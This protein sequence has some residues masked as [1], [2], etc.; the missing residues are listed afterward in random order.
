MNRFSLLRRSFRWI[1]P[2][3]A[4]LVALLQ[5]APAARLALAADEAAAA[6]PIG[7]VLRNAGAALGALGAI[8]T[9]AGATVL[10]ATA[11]SPV[12]VTVGQAAQPIVFTVTNTIAIGT[13]SIGG[14]IPPGMQ[15]TAVEGGANLSSP[16][17]LD[18]TTPGVMDSYGD[19]SGA[20]TTTTPI[21]SGTPTRAGSYTMTFQAFEYAGNGNLS[22][23]TFNFTVNV[24]SSGPPPS[25][26]PAFTTQPA[27][28]TVAPGTTVV[29]NAAASGTP[30]PTYQWKLNG[31]AISGAT[32]ARLV[33]TG[34]AAGAA[35]AYTCTAT[36][37]AGAVT[38]SA[39]TLAFTATSNPGRLGNISV[40]S[41]FAAGQL[42]TVGFVTGG[43]GTSGT[44]TLLI[45]A[46]GPS[47]AAVAGLS[48]TM[49]HPSLQV[50]PLGQSTVI[51]ANSAW[52]TPASNGTL[53]TAADAATFA[54]P[55]VAGSLDAALV[56]PL[57]PGGYSVQVS[58]TGAGT[59]LTELYDD[60]PLA[61]YTA[62][63]P[64]LV[65]ISCNTSLP[66][67]GSVTAGFT[68][69]GVTAKTV[70][71]RASGPTLASFGLSGTMADP[72]IQVYS[73]STV[74][75]ADA[76]WGGDP[77]IAAAAASV[78]GFAFSS[79][80][81]LDSAVLLTLAPGSY[82]AV[83]SSASGGGGTTVLEVYEVP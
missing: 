54:F 13:W 53:V 2:P 61:A 79:P 40:L 8:H 16:G 52:G 9:L 43:A 22:S 66:T 36:N 37:S 42:L 25:V 47:L 39:G 12:T 76:G 57:T 31:T 26:A 71:I 6:V 63:T 58:G 28:T 15:F 67:G 14:N 23:N 3:L 78:Q 69:G 48:G 18:A 19:T 49:A 46:D 73:G 33:L 30:T 82:S 77:Q 72:Q 65:N 70:L 68:V 44:Q 83:A 21:L 27:S 75:A 5:R 80:T 55:L 51:A 24:V 20:I 11:S 38:S 60:T 56:T 59:A 74:L 4:T 50:I 17:T 41:N 35:G 29:F 81:S 64:R 62:A 1:N 45:R 34:A 10:S 7:A 32:S